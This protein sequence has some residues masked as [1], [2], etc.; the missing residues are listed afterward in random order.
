[1]NISNKCFKNINLLSINVIPTY[2]Y[3]RP[4]YLNHPNMNNFLRLFT[5]AL[6]KIYII[7]LLI[8]RIINLNQT[9]WL[10]SSL[11]EYK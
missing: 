3:V 7:I 4:L 2:Q 9:A 11:T 10:G 5:L 8:I 1:M 6:F